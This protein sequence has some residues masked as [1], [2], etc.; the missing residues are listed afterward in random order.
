MENEIIRNLLEALEFSPDNIPLRLQVADMMMKERLY[1][2]A[3]KQYQLVL[4]KQ[5]GNN[6]A[7]A[8]LAASY[9]QRQKYSAA[10]VVY[11]QIAGG[12]TREDQVLYIK[13][14]IKENS[15]EQAI[16]VYQELLAQ[17][18]DFT[19]DE[20]DTALRMPSAGDMDDLFDGMGNSDDAYFM[21]KPNTNFSDVGGMSKVKEEISIKIIQPLKKSRVVQGIWQKK[22][23][24]YFAVRPSRLWQ[25]IYC[26]SYR[27]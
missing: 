13:S 6:R 25:N 14:L 16:A 10:I 20:I 5:Y 22:W 9:Y 21:E 1:E 18:P 19:D 7:S 27:R 24:W 23:W 4:D 15:V 26:E 17:Y 12:L 3:A 8:G 2:D 11:E